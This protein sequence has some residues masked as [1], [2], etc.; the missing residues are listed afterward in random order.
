MTSHYKTKAANLATK[1]NIH[2]P[3][4]TPLDPNPCYLVLGDLM[5][6]VKVISQTKKQISHLQT[7]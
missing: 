6:N 1:V 2:L 4:Y 3:L 5:G 7:I